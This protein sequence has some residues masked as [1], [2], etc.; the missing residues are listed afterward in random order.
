[1]RADIDH[2]P[3]RNRRELNRIVPAIFE[4]FED[5]HKFASGDRKMARILKVILYGSFAR[6]DWIYEP[7]TEKAYASDYDILIIVNDDEAAKDVHWLDL[8]ERLSRDF[9]I[10]RHLRHSVSLIVHTLQEVNSNLAQGRFFFTDI[11]AEGIALYQSDDSE[12][13]TPKPKTPADALA[14]TQEYFEEWFPSAGAFYKMYEAALSEGS[15]GIFLKNAVFQLH[16]ATERLYHTVL[17]TCT[18]YTPHSHNLE[19]LRN[20]ANKLDRRLLHVWPSET[21][22]DG[23]R[24]GLLKDAYVKARYSKQYHISPEDLAWLGERVRELSGVVQTI[25]SERIASLQNQ[26]V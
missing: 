17:L 15:S 14:L 7:T 4:E 18:L 1:M 23:R 13:A 11:A 22:A 6:G 16:Q 19:H 8:E 5:A 24:F 9:S 26:A 12:L 20:L 25:A 3:E 10:L 2:L 21:K